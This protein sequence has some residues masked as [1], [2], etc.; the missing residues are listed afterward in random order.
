MSFDSVYFLSL[1]MVDSI[2]KKPKREKE[3]TN[4]AKQTIEQRM[5]QA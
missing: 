3:M 2:E 5:A 1:G 4:D